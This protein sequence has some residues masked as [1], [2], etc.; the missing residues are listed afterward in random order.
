MPKVPETTRLQRS[1][2][3]FSDLDIRTGELFCRF[4][5]KKVSFFLICNVYTIG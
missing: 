2:S 1:K 3:E 4:C 5:E